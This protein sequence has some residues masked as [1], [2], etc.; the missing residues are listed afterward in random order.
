MAGSGTAHLRP[1]SDPLLSVE[2]LV[3]EFPL[4][5]TGL[6]VNAVSGISFDVLKGETLGL[7]GESGCGKSTTGRAIMQ[8]PRQTGGHVRF[9]GS[10]L[11]GLAPD[12]VRRV[13][14]QMQM[15]FQ[16]PISSL[17]PR[18]KVKD[19]VAEPLAIWK[20]GSDD[21]REQRVRT[22]LEDVGIDPEIAAGRKP[23]QFSGGQC[24]R[25]CVAR[26]LV[27][28]PKLVI[29]D[30]PVSALDVSVQAQILNLLEDMKARYGLT[31]IFI[32]HDLAV[33]K[34]ISDRV[35]VMYLGKICEVA[36]PDEL[37]RAPAHPY[38]E[39]LLK[40]IPVP[41]PTV[42]PDTLGRIKGELPSP[43]FPPSGCRFRTR[44]PKAAD[45]C[46]A[47]EPQIR[48]LG[49]GHYVACHFPIGHAEAPPTAVDQTVPVAAPEPDTT[50]NGDSPTS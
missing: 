48:D 26:A 36:P 13:R 12:D 50:M 18:R 33:V 6:R 47:E 30:E 7:V 37:Y 17:N 25:I 39:L 41:D 32:A 35:C 38:T 8:L 10:E 3:V 31:M 43:V 27:L 5:N 42:T 1:D 9:D 2:D 49:G 46:A 45:R 16:D 19:I 20:V 15:I 40:S 28:D 29:C 14:P 34:N 11:T 23:H 24:Q 22:V 44:C 4:G 21:E